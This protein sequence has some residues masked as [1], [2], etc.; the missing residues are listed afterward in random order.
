MDS[1]KTK[2]DLWSHRHKKRSHD[3]ATESKAPQLEQYE[4]FEVNLQNDEPI[5]VVKKTV[6]PKPHKDMT[7]IAYILYYEVGVQ[8]YDFNASGVQKSADVRKNNVFLSDLMMEDSTKHTKNLTLWNKSG[9]AAKVVAFN[10][11]HL[12]PFTAYKIWVRAFYNTSPYLTVPDLSTHLSPRSKPLYVMT[13]VE[14]PSEPIILKLSCDMDKGSL[15]IQWRQPLYFNNTLNQYVVTL[16]KIPEHHPR[17]TVTFPT[18]KDDLETFFSVPV[19]LWNNTRYEVIL[20][21]VTFSIAK[22]GSL[23][24]GKPSAAQEVSSESCVERGGEQ[25][26]V[27][28]AGAG[29]EVGDTET[30]PPASP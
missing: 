18:S 23:V 8:N 17:K 20:Y 29:A 27:G 22:E 30:S 12:K 19:E 11:K 16:R 28:A 24:M 4:Y 26:A 1:Y 21:A 25:G 6:H 10:L 14:P 9:I 15:Y 2:R 7:Q 13:D 3:N 5:E